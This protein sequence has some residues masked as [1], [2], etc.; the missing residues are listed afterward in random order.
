MN[1]TQKRL[2]ELVRYDADTGVFY[3]ITN[4]HT[5]LAGKVLGN[6]NG[7]GY[8]QICIDRKM[9]PAHRLAW[10]YVHGE[11]PSCTVDHINGGKTDNRLVNLRLATVAQNR[12]NTGPNKNSTH[13]VKGVT[14]HHRERKWSARYVV[15]GKRTC[16]GYFDTVEQAGA[17]YQAAHEKLHGEFSRVLPFAKAS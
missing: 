9:W 2:Q 8:V 14:F 16:L 10:L 3:A 15:N 5:V 7:N 11:M 12:A 6:V 17:A 13:G 1:L 4:R